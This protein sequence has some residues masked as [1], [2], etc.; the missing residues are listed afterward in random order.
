MDFPRTLLV[1][2]QRPDGRYAGAEVL[3]KILRELP[4]DK[5]R[6]AC[7]AVPMA[8]DAPETPAHRAFPPRTLTWRLRNYTVNYWFMHNLQSNAVARKIAEWAAPFQ[9][10][11]IWVLAEM[12]AVNVARHLGGRLGVPIHATVH[13][14]YAFARFAVPQRYFPLYLHDVGRLMARVRSMDAVSAALLA[15]VLESLAPRSLAGTMVFPAS[16]SRSQMAASPAARARLSRRRKIGLCGS[17]RIDAGQWKGFL[18]L[19]GDLPFEFEIIAFTDL[20]AFSDEHAPANVTLVPQDY[21]RT[22][23]DVVRRFESEP[24]DACYLG[25]TQ[26]QDQRMFAARSLSSKLT[27]YAAAG[28]PIIVHGPAESA[29]WHLVDK[30]DAGVLCDDDGPRALAALRHL[31]SDGEARLRMAEGACRLCRAEFDLETNAARFRDLLA[32][33]VL[34]SGG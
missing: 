19:L 2:W 7:L 9:P 13:D 27:T 32:E 34:K 28:C 6:W 11:I 17:M 10:Q 26:R 18:R 3:R 23:E 8:G 30:Y 16:I 21:A 24:V 1:S 33:T 22:E 31:L 5:V 12:G 14:S 4:R 20:S 15:D 25:I 29:A